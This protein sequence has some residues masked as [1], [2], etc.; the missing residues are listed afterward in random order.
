MSNRR[1]RDRPKPVHRASRERRTLRSV[2]A[3]LKFA[4]CFEEWEREAPSRF[5]KLRE[6][7]RVSAAGRNAMSEAMAIL[8]AMKTRSQQ[9]ILTGFLAEAIGSSSL[10]AIF[11][12]EVRG[13]TAYAARAISGLR[14]AAA[15][16]RGLNESDKARALV[17]ELVEGPAPQREVAAKKLAWASQLDAQAHALEQEQKDFLNSFSTRR[18]GWD[19]AD[20]KYGNLEWVILLEGHLSAELGHTPKPAALALLLKSAETAWPGSPKSD[21]ADSINL[22]SLEKSLDRF[23]KQNPNWPNLPHPEL[24]PLGESSGPP[25]RETVRKA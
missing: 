3:P 4:E 19:S 7:V 16:I 2:S 1:K 17:V 23:R 15:A 10:R 22:R 24:Q 5:A 14:S 12:A 21:S 9:S 8:S 20:K 13:R 18:W 6:A 11:D 25:T